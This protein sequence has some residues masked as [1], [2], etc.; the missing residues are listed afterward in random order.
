ML[1]RAATIHS[2][3]EIIMHAARPVTR[4]FG[5]NNFDVFGV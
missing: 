5:I 1:K 4:Y 3:I 2:R